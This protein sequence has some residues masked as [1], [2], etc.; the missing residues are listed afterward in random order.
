MN[1]RFYACF[2]APAL[3]VA[4]VCPEPIS[5][6]GFFPPA[7]DEAGGLLPP[8]HWGGLQPALDAAVHF[9]A[10]SPLDLPL[11]HGLPS[12]VWATFTTGYIPTSFDIIAGM[13]DGMGLLG[14]TK[15]MERATRGRGGNASEAL[16]S[17]LALGEYL[18][19][20]ANTPAQGVWGNVTRSTGLNFEWPLSTSSQGDA[21]FGLNCIETDRVGIAGFA[22]LKLHEATGGVDGRYFAQALHNARVLAATQAPGNAT[23]APWPFRVDSVSGTFL[24]G[25]K[26]GESAFPLRLLLALSRPPYSLAEFAAPAAALWAWVRDFQL[27]TARANVTPAE[28]LFVNFFEDRNSALDSNRNSWTALEL[29][30]LLIEERKS[31]LDPQW[32]QHVDSLLTY[33]TALFGYPS[34][35]G[36]CTLMGEQDDDRKGWGGANSKLGAV[37]AMFACAGGPAWWGGVGA[38][39]AAHHAYFTA[40]D[41][42]R[43]AE[44]Y[45]VNATPT[46]G[47]WTED[48]WLDVLHNLVDAAEAE[49]GFC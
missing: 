16:P 34:G 45:L 21:D 4:G 9:Y 8:A 6:L 5:T 26:N 32:M 10:A 47:G 15:Y 36:N 27:P 20:W 1:V 12:M 13:Q 39:N 43:S 29:A 7:C 24:N 40:L 42:C 48:A 18:V 44:A 14:Y 35:V 23:H 30:R 46:R 37:A 22:L 11:S 2:L 33:A 3:A 31:G 41:G 49:E 17:A 19:A 28:C 38:R 25:H